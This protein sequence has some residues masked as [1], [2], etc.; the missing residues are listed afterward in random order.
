MNM[1]LFLFSSLLF[2]PNPLP[3]HALRPFH[4][5]VTS[6]PCPLHFFRKPLAALNL[7]RNSRA[8]FDASPLLV[9]TYAISRVLQKEKAVPHF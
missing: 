2:Y 3:L 6:G 1:L 7:G 9:S 4:Y 8:G 5:I